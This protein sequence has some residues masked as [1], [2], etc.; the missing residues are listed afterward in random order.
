MAEA[1]H[2]RSDAF[3][4]IGSFT[5]ILG[6]RLGF[7]ILDPI[8]G[9]IICLFVFKIAWDI[10][11]ETFEKLI[12]TACDD[13]TERQ[14]VRIAAATDGVL[15]IDDLKTRLFGAKIYV[16]IEIAVDEDMK[17]SD[18][19]EIAEEVHEAIEGGV[20]GVK[21]CMVHLNP[22]KIPVDKA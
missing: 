11:K 18:A 17:L 8:A 12:D 1:W 20:P 4:S 7:P 14:I 2:H 3:S 21:H 22:E 19:H 16:D 13:E 9:I 6:S 5:G 10:L 15:H